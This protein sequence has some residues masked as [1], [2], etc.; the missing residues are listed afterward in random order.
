M[1][2]F[3]THITTST[4][5]GIAYGGAGLWLLPEP[6]GELPL[7]ACVLATGLCSIGGML[8]DLDSDSGIP[9]RETVAFTAAVVPML[10]IHRWSHLGLS[11]EMMVI[12]G[13]LIYLLIRFGLFALLKP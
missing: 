1:A 7:A 9:L 10:L 11:H 4:T 3:K 6:G 2:G 13:G 5:L 12:V 8:P